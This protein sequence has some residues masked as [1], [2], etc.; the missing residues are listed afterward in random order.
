MVE[1]LYGKEHIDYAFTLNNLSM[2]LKDLG[3]Y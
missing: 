1:K 3:E 2:S